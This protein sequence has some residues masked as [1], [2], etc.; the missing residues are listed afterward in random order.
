MK[1]TFEQGRDGRFTDDGEGERGERDAEL[2]GGEIGVE[3]VEQAEQ[4]DRPPV[5]LLR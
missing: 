2:R 1:R 4:A 5:A 3:I